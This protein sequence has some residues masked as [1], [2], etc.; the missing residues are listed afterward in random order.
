M[1]AMK[2]CLIVIA[3]AA[4]LGGSPAVAADMALKAPPLPPVSNWTGFYVGLN[5]GAAVNDSRYNLDPS[6]CF[7]TNPACGGGPANN[8]LRSDAR[9]FTDSSFTGGG[10]AGYNWQSRMLVWGVEAD[11]NYK[12]ENTGDNVNRPVLPPLVGNFLHS[13][14]DRM[15]WF[16]T[17]RGRF[18]FLPTPNLLIYGTGGLAY[19]QVASSTAVSFTS[20]TDAYAGSISTTRAGWTAGAGGEWKFNSNWSAKV[21]YLYVDL[22]TVGYTNAC[23]TAVCALIVPPPAYRTD[24]RVIDNIFRVGVSYHFGSGPV[25]AL[26]WNN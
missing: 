14:S 7:L 8:P 3:A 9:T 5:A 17:V 10:Q 21:E 25:A 1:G 12:G 6:G 26:M 20:T 2:K 15:D 16:G 22:G 23:T 18:G 13:T 11:I 4:I 19:G 24:L